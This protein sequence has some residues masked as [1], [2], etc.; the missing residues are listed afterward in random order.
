MGVLRNSFNKLKF[1]WSINWTK[2]LYFNFKKFPFAT[3]KKLP[4]VFFG[5]VKF[6]DIS[7]EIVINTPIESGLFGF[8]HHFEKH[9]TSKGVAEFNL[10]GKLTINGPMHMGKDVFFSVEKD[11][12]C[13]FGYMAC[14]GSD[15]RFLC[16]NHITLGDWTGIGYQSQVIDTNSHPMKNS[17]TGELYPIS[18]PI[19]LGSHN[20]VSNRVSIMPNTTTPDYCVIASNSLCS[21]DY[22]LLGNNVLIGGVPAKLIKQNYTRD[23]EAEKPLLKK[24]KIIEMGLFR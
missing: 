17:E 16:T 14:L 7:G 19:H 23:W 2:T 13:E 10:S 24:Y 20:A 21:K 8:G 22:S 1:Y 4:F 3:A 18:A 9:K 15:V 5:K 6:H 11:A 12:L